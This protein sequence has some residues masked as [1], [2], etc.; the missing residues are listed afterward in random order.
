VLEVLAEERLVHA[1]WVGRVPLPLRERRPGN[2]FQVGL[3]FRGVRYPF[4]LLEWY[5]DVG[6]DSRHAALIRDRCGYPADAIFDRAGNPARAPAHV[7]LLGE[8]KVLVVARV[9]FAYERPI[10]QPRR[11][12][13]Q[14]P[15]CSVDLLASVSQRDLGIAQSLGGGGK[16]SWKKAG[17]EWVLRP[18]RDRGPPTFFRHETN[19]EACVLVLVAA[20]GRAESTRFRRECQNTVDPSDR[21]VGF[22]PGKQRRISAEI[23]IRPRISHAEAQ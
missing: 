22:E 15:E 6:A 4:L 18:D 19:L 2:H 8:G 20:V 10:S 7:R 21:E 3:G 9:V 14:A 12:I 16:L 13:A 11:R 5:R 17:A 1:P 23:E